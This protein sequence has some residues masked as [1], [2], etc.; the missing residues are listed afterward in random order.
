MKYVLAL[1]V[2]TPLSLQEGNEEIHF[3]SCG[4]LCGRARRAPKTAEGRM[5]SFC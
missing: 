4:P 3:P 5:L 1:A 2:S